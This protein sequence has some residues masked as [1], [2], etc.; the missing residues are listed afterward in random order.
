MCPSWLNWWRILLWWNRRSS[1][2][3]HFLAF[4]FL[5]IFFCCCLLTNSHGKLLKSKFQCICV[6]IFNKR[7][8]RSIKRFF[9]PFGH[10]WQFFQPL[11]RCVWF[12]LLQK[13]H[14]L[15]NHFSAIGHI[16]ITLPTKH[17]RARGLMLMR[18]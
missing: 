2:D 16:S 18:L 12:S 8:S 7:L 13:T 9:K 5:R 15:L 14:D 4:F 1:R 11:L 6:V 3:F 17:L 10:L